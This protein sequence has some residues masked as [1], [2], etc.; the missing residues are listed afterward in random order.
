[1]IRLHSSFLPTV[2]WVT[3]AVLEGE[4]LM[5]HASHFVKQTPRNRCRI[6]GPNGAQYL[7]VPVRNRN[8]KQA[9]GEV[10]I[11]YDED[12]ISQHLQAIRTAYRSAPYYD[13]LYPEI[14]EIYLRRFDRLVELNEALIH[15]VFNRLH[16]KVSVEFNSEYQAISDDPKDARN[17][18]YPDHLIQGVYPQVFQEKHG[19]IADCSIL[20]RLMNQ[21]EDY[22][23]SLARLL[24]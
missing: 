21:L 16:A 7:I 24:V 15:W 19:F 22:E 4:V 5:D 6:C 17:W 9:M 10:L 1:M 3:A 2:D 14:E 13:Y 18:T 11:S 12:W 23:V 20:D 8:K